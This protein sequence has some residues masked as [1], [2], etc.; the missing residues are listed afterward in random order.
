MSWT[1]AT[2]EGRDRDIHDQFRKAIRAAYSKDI[3]LFGTT[4]KGHVYPA[5]SH[6]EIICIGGADA[7]GSMIPESVEGNPR[8][9]FPS[10]DLGSALQQDGQPPAS[11]SS[12]STALAAGLAALILYCADF[13][14]PGEARQA[15]KEKMP[16]AF[17]AMTAKSSQYVES[18]GFFDPKNFDYRCE[19]TEEGIDL[20][21]QAIGELMKA[22]KLLATSPICFHSVMLDSML[23]IYATLNSALA[24][25]VI[26]STRLGGW[27]SL[28]ACLVANH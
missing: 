5:N 19:S 16:K 18:K 12:I 21:R 11:G 22:A 13:S 20:I 27:H 9:T 23:T 6:P 2:P 4:S 14:Y 25:S 7:N 28:M 17:D 15:L 10:C 8:F 24:G 1:I 3:L 26:K